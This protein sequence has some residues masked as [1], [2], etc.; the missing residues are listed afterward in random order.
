MHGQKNV[1]ICSFGVSAEMTVYYFEPSCADF[2]Q[3][4]VFW[5]IAPPSIRN[6]GE[7]FCL[8]LKDD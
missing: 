5:V 6:F 3:I 7:I 2:I 1:K 8:H 4:I